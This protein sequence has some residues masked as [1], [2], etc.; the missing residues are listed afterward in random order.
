MTPFWKGARFWTVGRYFFASLFALLL[1]VP[2]LWALSGSI[3]TNASLFADPY[4][5]LPR[6]AHWENYSAS[7]GA[8]SFGRDLLNSFGIAFVLATFGVFLGL[9]AGYALGKG[10]FLG[11][12]FVFWAIVSTLLL[13]F[14]AILIP[15]FVLATKLHMVNTY[16]GV[17]I[18]GL[19]TAQ[20]VFFMRQYVLGI[21]DELIESARVDGASELKVYLRVV[22]PLCWPVFASMGVLVFVGSWNNLLWPLVVINSQNLYTVPLGL[23]HFSSEYFTN[24]VGILAMSVVGALPVLFVFLFLRKRILDSVMVSGGAVKG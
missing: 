20:V 10:K 19:L 5:W 8:I 21:P 2:L 1:L 9:M 15:V 22:M 4:Q 23:T 17:I 7:W 3:H 11:R 6:V 18:P 12:D 16:L 13:P 24:Y 14:P